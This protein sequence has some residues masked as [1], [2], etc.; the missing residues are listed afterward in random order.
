MAL[1]FFCSSVR[2]GAGSALLIP[3]QRIKMRL[4]LSGI[5]IRD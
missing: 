1:L 3:L 4:I 5:V 2:K